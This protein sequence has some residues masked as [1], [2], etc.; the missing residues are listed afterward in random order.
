MK[1]KIIIAT[2]LLILFFVALEIIKLNQLH[3]SVS[4]Y[5]KYWRQQSA[6]QGEFVYVA[7]GDSA[8]QGIGASRPE[9]GYV[10]LLIK[11]VEQTTGKSVHVLNLSESGAKIEDVINKQIPQLKNIKPDLMTIEVGSNDVANDYDTQKFQQQYDQLA[12]LLPANTFVA[13]IPYFGGRLKYNDKA[14]DA[15]KYVQQAAQKHNLKLV[16]LQTATKQEQSIFNYS[17]D[18]F[19]PSNRAYKIWSDAFWKIIG[20]TLNK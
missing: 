2:G 17:V 12:S 13:N 15:S 16:D 8:A 5:A 4:S 1:K 19:H 10:G 9:L 6:K 20:P 11:Q 7:L 3:Q 18:F 14:I